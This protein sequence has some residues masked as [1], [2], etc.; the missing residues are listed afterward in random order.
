MH[1][2]R[3]RECRRRCR[4]VGIVAPA[5]TIGLVFASPG[6]AQVQLVNRTADVGLTAIHRPA[7]EMFRV[8]K[9]S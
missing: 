1:D 3:N 8:S 4:F 6:N 7:S 9:S 5:A 2:L